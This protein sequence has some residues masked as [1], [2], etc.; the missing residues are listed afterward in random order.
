MWANGRRRN[1]HGETAVG[2]MR[3]VEMSREHAL[4]QTVTHGLS[5]SRGQTTQ[6]SGLLGNFYFFRHRDRAREGVVGCLTTV[7]FWSNRHHQTA[8]K[9]ESS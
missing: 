3:G 4:V 9:N 5:E 6:P 8:N 1:R 7:A 2:D